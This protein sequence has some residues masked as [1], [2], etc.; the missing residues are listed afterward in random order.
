MILLL[1]FEGKKIFLLK[2]SS[3]HTILN[4]TFSSFKSRLKVLIQRKSFSSKLT[5]MSIIEWTI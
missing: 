2:H 1:D 5:F 4:E 3:V